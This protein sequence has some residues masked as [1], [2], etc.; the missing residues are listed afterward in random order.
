MEGYPPYL[1]AAL[2]ALGALWTSPFYELMF[3]SFLAVRIFYMV[4]SCMFNGLWPPFGLNV[5]IMFM[6]LHIFFEH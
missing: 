1:P 5:R 4:R 3:A 2:W 6:I